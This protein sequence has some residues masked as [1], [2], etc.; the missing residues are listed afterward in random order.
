MG[1]L[2]IFLG[3]LEKFEIISKKDKGTKIYFII[4]NL[5]YNVYKEKKN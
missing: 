1:K 3:P 5:E 2:V 4:V